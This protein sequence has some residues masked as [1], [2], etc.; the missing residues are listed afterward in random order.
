MIRN[1][2]C[3]VMIVIYIQSIENIPVDF[4]SPL[5]FRLFA[6]FI[7]MYGLGLSP[8]VHFQSASDLPIVWIYAVIVTCYFISKAK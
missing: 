5:N 2:L 3:K 4:S 1:P 8:I 6:C 7:A